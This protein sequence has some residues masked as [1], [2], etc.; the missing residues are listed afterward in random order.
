MANDAS[1]DKAIDEISHMSEEELE[2]FVNLEL[3]GSLR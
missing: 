1:S 3:Q 2:S